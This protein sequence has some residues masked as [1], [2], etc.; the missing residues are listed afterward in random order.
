[1]S[2]ERRANLLGAPLT[3]RIWSTSRRAL[4]R[5]SP[6]PE[7]GSS[8][9]RTGRGPQRPRRTFLRGP[10]ARARTVPGPC[11]RPDGERGDRARTAG[12]APVSRR[13]PDPGERPGHGTRAGRRAAEN[14]QVLPRTAPSS[15]HRPP[16]GRAR[17]GGARIESG[18][19]ARSLRR[20]GPGSM[21]PGRE[22][23]R[24]SARRPAREPLRSSPSAG[25]PRGGRSDGSG[26]SASEG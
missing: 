5:R 1:M 15:P 12:G 2:E 4:H 7:E 24:S 8:R 9:R 10:R 26:A 3:A 21:S 13:R 19:R 16:R 11:S 23:P 22:S 25:L 14:P 20:R 18:R 6:R 17:P